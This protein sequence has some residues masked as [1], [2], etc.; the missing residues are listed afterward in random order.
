M[1]IGSVYIGMPTAHADTTLGAGSNHHDATTAG[2]KA[3]PKSVSVFFV[4]SL[5]FA[6]AHKE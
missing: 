1:T 6:I 4:L 5:R 3:S 2:N